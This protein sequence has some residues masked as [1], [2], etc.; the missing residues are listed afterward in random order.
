MIAIP[1]LY[2][3]AFRSHWCIFIIIL[4]SFC[5]NS[6]ISYGVDNQNDCQISAVISIPSNECVNCK[7]YVFRM[8]DILT[9]YISKDSIRIV[10]D[11]DAGLYYIE[12]NKAKFYGIHTTVNLNQTNLISPDSKARIQCSYKK[13]V[14]NFDNLSL[15]GSLDSF[16]NSHCKNNS[17]VYQPRQTIS[18]TAILTLNVFGKFGD[19]LIELDSNRMLFFSLNTNSGCFLY[20]NG[21]YHKEELLSS[22]MSDTK[23]LE[24]CKRIKNYDIGDGLKDIKDFSE[25]SSISP[26]KILAYANNN[27]Y[28]YVLFSYFTTQKSYPTKDSILIKYITNFAIG[29]QK[30]YT[31][32]NPLNLDSYQEVMQFDTITIHSNVYYP[33]TLQPFIVVKGNYVFLPVAKLGRDSSLQDSVVEV[34]KS[35]FINNGKATVENLLEYIQG[36]YLQSFMV[37]Y[38]LNSEISILNSITQTF[39]FGNSITSLFLKDVHYTSGEQLALTYI[40]DYM[41][42]DGTNLVVLGYSKQGKCELCFIDMETKKCTSY[43]IETTSAPIFCKLISKDKAI[44]IYKQ[45]KMI[46][47]N[48]VNLQKNNK[49]KE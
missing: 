10:T 38:D 2:T 44:I 47:S 25:T 22:S 7:A 34:L 12:K 49:K 16:L 18:D 19:K 26:Y 35:E 46:I 3:N 5:F 14:A 36:D 33:R 17:P 27:G 1:N 24:L 28:L 45:D 6:T 39:D 48:I 42:D 9:R 8:L 11:N 30:T 37:K 31:V 41:V 4:S 13:T 21:G 43:P 32:T 23:Y 15:A 29:R 40:Y 20:K